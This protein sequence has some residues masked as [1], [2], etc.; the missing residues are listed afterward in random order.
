MM[1]GSVIG[2]F[3]KMRGREWHFSGAKQAN[4]TKAVW[5]LNTRIDRSIPSP[6]AALGDGFFAARKTPPGRGAPF[7]RNRVAFAVF[8][9]AARFQRLKIDWGVHPSASGVAS[10]TK[11]REIYD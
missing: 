6:D 4:Q 8:E 5:W 7:Q 2:K 9:I 11:S 1:A 3:I 10:G